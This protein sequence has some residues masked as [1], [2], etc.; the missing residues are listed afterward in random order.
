MGTSSLTKK[1]GILPARRRLYQAR[2]KLANPLFHKPQTAAF[3]PVSSRFQAGFKP[4]QQ[5]N[6][7]PQKTAKSPVKTRFSPGLHPVFRADL[8][9]EVAERLVKL[10]FLGCEAFQHFVSCAVPLFAEEFPANKARL[11]RGV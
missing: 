10:F 2:K 11:F 8:F 9:E 7:R 6:Q 3:K 5:P 4:N 1:A